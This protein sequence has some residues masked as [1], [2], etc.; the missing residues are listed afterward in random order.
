MPL[1]VEPVQPGSAWTCTDPDTLQFSRPVGPLIW[2]FKEFRTFF[3]PKE[4]K[5]IKANYSALDLPNIPEVWDKSVWWESGEI[6]LTEESPNSQR[7]AIDAY[8]DKAE[9]ERM[10]SEAATDAD[11]YLI[12]ECLWELSLTC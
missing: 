8:F 10:M 2:E 12:A 5:Q 7:D 6:N 11:H 4:A 1:T 3:F 9:V